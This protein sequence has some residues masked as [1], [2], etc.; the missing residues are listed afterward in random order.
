MKRYDC[1]KIVASEMSDA[2]EPF[3]PDRMA[4]QL[5]FATAFQR[6]FIPDRIGYG[7]DAVFMRVL[8][9]AVR[10]ADVD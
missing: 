8:R 10:Q 4:G 7:L 6:H 9:A 5:L 3:Y 1:L 2:L